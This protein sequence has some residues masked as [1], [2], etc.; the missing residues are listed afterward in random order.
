[1]KPVAEVILSAILLSSPILAQKRIV[2][3]AKLRDDV[4]AAMVNANLKDK[5]KKTLEESRETL[6][7]AVEARR[8][9]EPMDRKKV[10]KAFEDI[11]KMAGTD[12]FGAED[13]AAVQ[14]DLQNLHASG[15]QNRPRKAA[16]AYPP[17]GPR[18]IGGFAA[19]MY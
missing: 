3:I 4:G 2:L 6:G 7:Q 13:R 1:M 17:R 12:A 9:G 19:Q 10:Q 15:A 5:Q 16:R 14:E 8:Q 18:R 11:R